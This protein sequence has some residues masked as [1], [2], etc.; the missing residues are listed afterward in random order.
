MVQRGVSKTLLKARKKYNEKISRS[1]VDTELS[2]SCVSS[3]SH[4][5]PGRDNGSAVK[6]LAADVVSLGKTFYHFMPFV[7]VDCD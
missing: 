6:V 5:K 4:D 3:A 1:D 7:N 2:S